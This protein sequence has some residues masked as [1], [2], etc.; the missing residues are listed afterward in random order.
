M[1]LTELN[2]QNFARGSPLFFSFSCLRQNQNQ[3]DRSHR[4]YPAGARCSSSNGQTDATTQTKPGHQLPD[5]LGTVQYGRSLN[6]GYQIERFTLYKTA[7]GPF[8]RM[9]RSYGFF[10]NQLLL[11]PLLAFLGNWKEGGARLPRDS[12]RLEERV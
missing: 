1:P 12:E 3:H 4:E 2:N 7:H 11:C 8:G 10:V 5:G 6:Q 9:R